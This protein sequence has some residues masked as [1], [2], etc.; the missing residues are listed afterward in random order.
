MIGTRDVRR[1]D[2]RRLQTAIAFCSNVLKHGRD[3]YGS[4]E[5]P[6]LVDGVRATTREPVVW[7]WTGSRE[8]EFGP[9][10]EW[11]P[12]NLAKQQNLFRTLVGMSALTGDER[13]RRAA[14]DATAHVLEHYQCGTGLLRWGGHQFVDLATKTVQGQAFTD[15][16]ELK[17]T[18]PYYELLWEVAPIETARYIEAVWNAHV[19]DWSTLDM[20]R[21]GEYDQPMGRLWDH[22]FADPPPFFEG[23]GLTFVNCGSDLVYAACHLSQFTGEEAPLRWA[24]RL[25]E[26]YVKARHPR[27]RLGVYQYSQARKE[28]DPPSPDHTNSRH[29]DR[30]KRQLGPEF[31][32]VAL[33]GNVVLPRHGRVVHG[34]WAIIQ[35]QLSQRLGAAGR[36]FVDWAC[37]GLDAYAAHAYVPESNEVRPLLADGTDLTGFALRRNGYYGEQGSTFEREAAGWLL[38]WSYTLGGVLGESPD[39]WQVARRIGQAHGLGDIGA[40][41]G[42]R[43]KVDLETT[44]SDPLAIFGLLEAYRAWS[45]TEYL[46][47]ARVVADNMV[48]ERFH[49]G[50]FLP[51][52]RHVHAC[53][54]RVE[55]LALLA[56]EATL[57]GTPDLVPSYSAGMGFLHGMV[58]DRTRATD[59]EYIYGAVA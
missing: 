21:H 24:K 3:V 45:F 41:P 40:A 53:F 48:E 31:G 10:G 36:E 34:N 47:V 14:V 7:R 26:Q 23:T 43:P 18:Y 44:V 32:E 25:A 5:T 59:D 19:L 57:R 50:L 38:F 35:L 6:L 1:D 58:D 54:D 15:C 39:L 30:A 37:E 16:H 20:N 27:T 2:D 33:E 56:L 51:S 46:D 22:G 55:P 42:R 49:H 9:P 8:A 17:T 28:A 12:S 13:Y 52:D 4:E 11:I 29:G